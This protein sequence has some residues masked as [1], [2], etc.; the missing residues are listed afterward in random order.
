MSEAKDFQ[1]KQI[2]VGDSIVTVSS[3]A[4]G[5]L[6]LLIRGVV[7]K[8]SPKMV[9]VLY[10]ALYRTETYEREVT[11]HHANVLVMPAEV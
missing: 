1:G 10:T 11:R 2:K 5:G 3:P 9:T 4:H 8:V 7:T 6:R